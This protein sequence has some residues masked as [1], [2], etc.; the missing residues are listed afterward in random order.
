[1]TLESPVHDSRSPLDRILDH[2]RGALARAMDAHRDRHPDLVVETGSL[3]AHA[4]FIPAVAELLSREERRG[5]K[6]MSGSSLSPR[7]RFRHIAYELEASTAVLLR[8][9]EELI[10]YAT[11]ALWEVDEGRVVEFCS[12]VIDDPFRGTGFGRVLVDARE[13]VAVEKF[14]P[15]GY[16]P[17]AF[18]NS[19]SA[20]I[21]NRELW[22][23][24]PWEWYSR[25]PVPVV[26]RPAC[27]ADRFSCDCTVL[28]MNLERL[29]ELAGVDPAELF[30]GEDEFDDDDVTQEIFEEDDAY[31]MFEDDEGG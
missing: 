2:L 12:A 15:G 25:Y 19:S 18:C 28:A 24:T 4:R 27:R 13:I 1:V 31:R 17:V 26:C 6:G 5:T 30:E 22:A 11:L 3:E 10:G 16:Q 23:E 8:D 7:D 9:G 20:R 21:Y 29:A 14:V